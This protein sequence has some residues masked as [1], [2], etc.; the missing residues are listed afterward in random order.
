MDLIQALLQLVV[1][2]LIDWDL[3]LKGRSISLGQVDIPLFVNI[4]HYPSLDSLGQHVDV[5][6]TALQG[7]LVRLVAL[8]Y[9]V[10]LQHLVPK[11]GELFF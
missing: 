8:S 3:A 10:K 11:L 5:E 4:L 9:L 2:S 1:A 7:G 6:C